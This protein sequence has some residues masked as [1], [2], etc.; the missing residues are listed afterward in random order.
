MPLKVDSLEFMHSFL[1]RPPIDENH[2]YSTPNN[3]FQ[4]LDSEGIL[5][6]NRPIAFQ[7]NSFG[8]PLPYDEVTISFKR[9]GP[10]YSACFL[11]DAKK[12]DV[13]TFRGLAEALAEKKYKF[14]S[15]SPGKNAL[16]FNGS[17]DIV[18]TIKAVNSDSLRLVSMGTAGVHTRVLPEDSDIFIKEV[19]TLE[20]VANSFLECQLRSIRD[21]EGVEEILK[22]M[23]YL[24]P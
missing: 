22:G 3:E 6:I 7:Y 23:I 4:S 16:I 14:V 2:G 8:L 17:G 24:N 21:A 9:F 12:P 13:F 1:K 20:S 15:L 5:T 11:V 19:G 18:F 10:Y